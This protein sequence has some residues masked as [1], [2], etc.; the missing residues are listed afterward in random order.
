MNN[1][2]ITD[3]YAY[4]GFKTTNVRAIIYYTNILW[5]LYTLN[6]IILVGR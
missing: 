2:I 6:N 3:F 4:D 5:L 1:D